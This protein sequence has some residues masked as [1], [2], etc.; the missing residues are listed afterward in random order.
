MKKTARTLVLCIT[1]SGFATLASAQTAAPAKTEATQKP[2]TTQTK[3]APAKPAPATPASQAGAMI[4]IDPITKEIRAPLPGEVQALTGGSSNAV[5]ASATLTESFS[6][7]GGGVGLMLDASTMV[8]MTVTKGPDGK[9]NQE[10][11]TGEKAAATKI[12]GVQFEKKQVPD[13]Q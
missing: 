4:F 13:V 10:C 7:P 1:A 8:Y 3:P 6:L 12:Q 11:V 2:A 5:T 9:L